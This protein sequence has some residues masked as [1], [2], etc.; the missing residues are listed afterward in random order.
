MALGTRPEAAPTHNPKA[1][2]PAIEPGFFFTPILWA[3]AGDRARL[4]PRR[5]ARRLRLWSAVAAVRPGAPLVRFRRLQ[6]C[7]RAFRGLLFRGIGR[8]RPSCPGFARR[9]AAR[10]LLWR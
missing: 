9:P 2:T 4:A 3:F 8:C 1:K 7:G 6:R 5:G 10:I